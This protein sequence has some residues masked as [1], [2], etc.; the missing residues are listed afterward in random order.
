GV[1][2]EVKTLLEKSYKPE[3]PVMKALGVREISAYISGKIS[4]E[5]TKTLLA[6]ATGQFIK[7]QQTWF[8]NQFD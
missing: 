5:E 2:E 3:A 8:K 1:V 6:L 4:L 7:R